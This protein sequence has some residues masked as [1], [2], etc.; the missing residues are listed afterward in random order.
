MED[1]PYCHCYHKNDS[2]VLFPN[3]QLSLL[4]WIHSRI[5]KVGLR[6]QDMVNTMPV[7]NQLRNYYSINC[8]LY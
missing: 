4:F 1:L 5:W 6:I 8:E 7:D 2:I 3:T